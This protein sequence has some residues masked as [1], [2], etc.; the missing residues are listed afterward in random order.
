MTDVPTLLADLETKI[1]ALNAIVASLATAAQAVSSDLN[2]LAVLLKPP[3][4]AK[5]D[6]WSKEFSSAFGGP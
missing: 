3:V 4:P 6:P 2:T 5:V 1:T